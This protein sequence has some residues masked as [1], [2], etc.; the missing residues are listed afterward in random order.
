MSLASTESSTVLSGP[1]WRGPRSWATLRGEA[2]A[3]ALVLVHD[4]LDAR[5]LW[6][7]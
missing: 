3:R 4:L 1:L 7:R 6:P 5:N 2:W